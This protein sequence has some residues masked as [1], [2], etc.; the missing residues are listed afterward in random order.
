MRTTLC[1]ATQGV[2]AAAKMSH[3]PAG[4]GSTARELQPAEELLHE[5]SSFPMAQPALAF[6]CRD[7]VESRIGPVLLFFR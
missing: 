6:M 7:H 3:G 5:L 2:P 1:A 4:R